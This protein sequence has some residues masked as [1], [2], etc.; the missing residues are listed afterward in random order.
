MMN[1]GKEGVQR[2]PALELA[3]IATELDVINVILEKSIE[4]KVDRYAETL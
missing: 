4:D 3:Q 2:E 1:V